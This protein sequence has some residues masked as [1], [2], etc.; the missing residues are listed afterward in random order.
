M[1]IIAEIATRRDLHHVLG[2]VFGWDFFD[3]RHVLSAHLALRRTFSDQL[4]P[5]ES[6]HGRF[7]RDRGKD[8][9]PKA[10]IRPWDVAATAFH[11][12]APSKADENISKN[13]HSLEFDIPIAGQIGRSAHCQ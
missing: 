1:A 13:G 3:G 9:W 11:V 10:G 4:L 5:P 2:P 6:L 8:N 7:A 12:P